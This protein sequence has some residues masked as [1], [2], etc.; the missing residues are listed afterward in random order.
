MSHN[1]KNDIIS[2]STY[3]LSGVIN[4]EYMNDIVQAYHVLLQ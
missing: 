4:L 2:T 3:T 1:K